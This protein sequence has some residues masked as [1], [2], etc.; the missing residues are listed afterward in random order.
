M[1]DASGYVIDK[2][3]SAFDSRMSRALRE[4]PLL[5]AVAGFAAGA[6]AAALFPPTNLEQQTLGPIGEQLS[7]E[8][9]RIGE[10]I[11]DTA[12]KAASTLKTAA[13]QHILETDGVK[14]IV[15]EVTEVVR[16]GMEPQRENSG[17]P[18]SAGDQNS[19][20]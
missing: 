1:T 20:R 4:Q 17:R 13:Q 5:I 19:N 8:A 3:Q 11:T 10:H 12:S 6:T 18:S 14:K 15:S 9:S 2:A 7:Q 16:D